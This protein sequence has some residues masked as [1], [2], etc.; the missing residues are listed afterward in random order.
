MSYKNIFQTLR[1][2]AASEAVSF[3][4]TS[5]QS[6]EVPAH[7]FEIRLVAT[8]D[9]FVEIGTNPTAATSTSMFISGDKSERYFHVHP[10]EKIAVI[11]SSTG[12]TLYVT[13]MGR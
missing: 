1:P 7:C 5:A 10:G 4:A 6:A 2:V 8:E 12:G 9:C 13:P 11:E 3:N